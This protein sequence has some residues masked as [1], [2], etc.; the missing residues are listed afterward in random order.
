MN[1]RLIES[2]RQ[3]IREGPVFGPFMKTGD[4]AFVEAAGYA[5]CDFA[6]LDMEHGPTRLQEIQNNNRAAPVTG[7]L[8]VIRVTSLS[9]TSISQELDHGPVGVQIP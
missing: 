1:Q 4:P 6:I 9:E 3:K 2:F 8:P 7:I 5:G